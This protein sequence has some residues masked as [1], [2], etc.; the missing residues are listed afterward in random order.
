[1]VQRYMLGGSMAE[2]IDGT[3]VS[4]IAYEQLTINLAETLDLA[5]EYF[6]QVES[7]QMSATDAAAALRMNSRLG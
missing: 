6:K 3:F 7:G 5:S 2:A 1:M 4:F